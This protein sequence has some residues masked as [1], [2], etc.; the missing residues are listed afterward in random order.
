[1]GSFERYD[2]FGWKRF[3]EDEDRPEKPR[4]YGLTEMRSPDYLFLRHGSLQVLFISLI[5][6]DTAA[7]SIYNFAKISAIS[8]SS[9]A[10]F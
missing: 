2:Y 1:M 10:S 5:D 7:L 4:S 3:T 9:I 6:S 8:I